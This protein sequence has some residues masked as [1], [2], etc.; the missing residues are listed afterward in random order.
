MKEKKEVAMGIIISVDDDPVV[1]DLLTEVFSEEDIKIYS[2]NNAFEALEI[3]S[4][5]DVDVAILDISMPQMNGFEIQM[6]LNQID[7][8]T[9]IIFLSTQMNK[10]TLLR[11][12]RSGTSD[13]FAKPFVP[14]ELIESVKSNQKKAIYF[15]EL[16]KAV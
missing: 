1:Q 6:A 2:I 7:P 16:R 3:A 15:R 8:Y 13:F 9:K 11:A 14:K 10:N 4:S 12:I 5:H